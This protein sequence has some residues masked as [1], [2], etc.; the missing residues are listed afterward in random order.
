MQI[1]RFE[2]FAIFGKKRRPVQVHGDGALF[3]KHSRAFVI[4]FQEKK[5]GKL[6]DV[7]TVGNS[8]IPQD[9]AVVPDTLD[10]GGGLGVHCLS[11]FNFNTISS[12]SFTYSSTR[13]GGGNFRMFWALSRSNC[14]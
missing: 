1:M 4:H 5:V 2:F 8:V 3:A 13:S 7:I 9:V 11:A 6:L 12:T 10:D 14:Q